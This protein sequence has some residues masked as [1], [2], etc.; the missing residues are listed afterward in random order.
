MRRFI[1]PLAFFVILCIFLG[2]GLHL[3]PHEIPSPFIGKPAPEFNLTQLND[4]QKNISPKDMRGQVWLLNVWA[5]WCVSCREEHPVLMDFSR[6]AIVPIIGLNYKDT[7]KEGIG[8]LQNEGNP[9]TVSGFD[10]DGRVGINYGVY[11]VPETFVIDKNGIIR[12]KHVGPVTQEVIAEKLLPLIKQLS[13][14]PVKGVTLGANQ[15]PARVL[16]GDLTKKFFKDIRH[17]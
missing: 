5:S 7:R 6:Q 2:V 14:E 15:E 11:G 1:C 12:M 17:A 9:Y 10:S 8:L 4:P 16:A 3:N 13:A